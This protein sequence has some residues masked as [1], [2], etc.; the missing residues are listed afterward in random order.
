[1]RN[2]LHSCSSEL[3]QGSRR[4]ADGTFEFTRPIRK[5]DYANL[6]VA[7]PTS[8]SFREN[9][10]KCSP[11]T[12]PSHPYAGAK[13]MQLVSTYNYNRSLSEER[14][15]TDGPTAHSRA[16]APSEIREPQ[17]TKC[18]SSSPKS[19]SFPFR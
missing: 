14:P 13:L 2:T 12:G 17:H 6:R 15:A 1:M 16:R 8:F 10:T 7:I 18:V 5:P 3:G 11:V 19:V 9:A 4:I